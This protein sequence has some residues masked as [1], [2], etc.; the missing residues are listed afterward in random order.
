[1]STNYMFEEMPWPDIEQRVR[2]CNI[3][4]IPLG[5]M[6]VQPAH[7]PVGTDTY[8]VEGLIRRGASLIADEVGALV[9]PPFDFGNPAGPNII[10]M[11]LNL[12]WDVLIEMLV[13]IFNDLY[14]QGFQRFVLVNGHG[15][16]GL[17]RPAAVPGDDDN[18]GVRMA[19]EGF[20]YQ[21]AFGFAYDAAAQFVEAGPDAEMFFVPI[22][23]FFRNISDEISLPWWEAGGE[24]DLPIQ[25]KTSLMLALHPHLVNLDKM[26]Q[27]TYLLS[28]Y[29]FVGNP[30]YGVSA[31]M[32][33]DRFQVKPSDDPV[34][35]VSAEIG[36]QLIGIWAQK[37]ADML[38][39]MHAK[40]HLAGRYRADA[41]KSNQP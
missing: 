36:E 20:S 7:L 18:D 6:E 28:P 1:M 8:I 41:Y 14:R 19:G 34:G 13:S 27:N 16:T 21:T 22:A 5:S 9:L 17:V 23:G 11:A 12:P 26:T 29:R 2:G 15:S 24:G 32:R 38:R 30:R 4:I 10:P 3:A 37:F 40:A 39:D 35:D 25:A 31:V 33:H